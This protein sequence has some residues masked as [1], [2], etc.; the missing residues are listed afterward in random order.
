MKKFVIF[1]IISIIVLSSVSTLSNE[2][3]QNL[4]IELDCA[5]I[6]GII[7]HFGGINCMM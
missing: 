6:D 4:I 7:R 5:Q 1:C 2:I 3:N